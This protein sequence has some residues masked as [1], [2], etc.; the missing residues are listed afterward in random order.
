RHTPPQP[1]TLHSGQRLRLVLNTYGIPPTAF[2]EW[3][4][5]SP[6]CLN[7]WFS[8]GAAS[9]SRGKAGDNLERQQSVA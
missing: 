9:G 6:Q 3:M 4:H 8:R 7:N 2:A 1:P 5:V